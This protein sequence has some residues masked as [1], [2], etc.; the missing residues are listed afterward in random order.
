MTRLMHNPIPGQSS[1]NAAPTF[2]MALQP[3]PVPS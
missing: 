3:A 1:L 2:E